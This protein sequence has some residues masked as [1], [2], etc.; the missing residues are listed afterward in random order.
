M[1]KIL[2]NIFQIVSFLAAIVAIIAFYFQFQ[3]KKPTLEIRNISSEKL[4]DL[5][6][7]DHLKATYVFKND[8][9]KSLWKLHYIISNSGDA[10]IIGEGNNKNIIKESLKYEINKGFKIIDYIVTNKDFPFE[11][12]N[13]DEIIEM[14]FLQWKPD[15]KFEL[16]FFVEQTSP[17][18]IPNITLNDREIING[19]VKYSTLYKAL[20]VKRSLFNRLPSLIREV[21]WWI[22][23]II[24]SSLVVVIPMFLISE[25][26]KYIRYKN[27]FRKNKSTYNEWIQKLITD[28]KLTEYKDPRNLPASLWNS[29]NNTKPDLP[30][31]DLRGT[32]IAIIFILLLF[33]IPLLLLIEI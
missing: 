13:S 20:N 23:L 22:S 15:E 30:D 7:I 8:T 18:S 29:Y 27:W 3:E 21:L 9:V 31:L 14:K 17:N 1:K 6:N 28:K 12:Y 16:I 25:I 26:L 2:N 4:T 10:I 33:I 19:S 11:V 5:P 32:S 24:Y